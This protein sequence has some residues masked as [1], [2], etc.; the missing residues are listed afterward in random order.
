V[1]DAQRTPRDQLD[2]A[3]RLVVTY[4]DGLM[5][6]D[7]IG[8]D[9]AFAIGSLARSLG[10]QTDSFVRRLG[11]AFDTVPAVRRRELSREQAAALFLRL[12]YS[13]Y[14]IPHPDPEELLAAL[15]SLAG[16]SRRS[17]VQAAG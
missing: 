12:A 13:H 9:P 8:V 15:R 6:P 17:S 7:P 3:L 16:L 14:L 2:A 10:P 5:G 4:L 1:I 11:A